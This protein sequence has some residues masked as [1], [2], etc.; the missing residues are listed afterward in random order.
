M[1]PESMKTVI[2]HAP[3]PVQRPGAPRIWNRSAPDQPAPKTVLASNTMKDVA[4]LAKGNFD[5]RAA[6]PRSDPI[7]RS[8]RQSH[9]PLGNRVDNYNFPSATEND[10][11]RPRPR[12]RARAPA[13]APRP[14]SRRRSGPRA[15][16]PRKNFEVKREWKSFLDTLKA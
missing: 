4:N 9:T 3:A 15:G 6:D 12:L 16:V 14:S 5:P 8:A 13:R 10:K 11:R 2:L 1:P 7:H